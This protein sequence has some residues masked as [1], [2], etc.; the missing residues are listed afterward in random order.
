MANLPTVDSS[1]LPQVKDLPL[2]VAEV[3]SVNL[4]GYIRPLGTIEADRPFALVEG[5]QFLVVRG[6]DR[7]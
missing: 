7:A 6:L 2:R 1:L 3:A 5:R 4:C